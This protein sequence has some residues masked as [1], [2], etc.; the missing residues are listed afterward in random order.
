MGR[1]RSGWRV[2]RLCG[3]RPRQS[4]DHP[5]GP[6]LEIGRRS[7]RSAWGPG[8]LTKSAKA[9]LADAFKHDGIRKILSYTDVQ[10]LRSQAVM[11]PLGLP[12]DPTLD[13]VA[14]YGKGPR[15]GLVWVARP[16]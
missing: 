13:F 14:D 8:Y 4:S 7:V 16:A 10:N 1:R 9:A 15:H 5:I 12:C 3:C 11:A 6:H 2:S